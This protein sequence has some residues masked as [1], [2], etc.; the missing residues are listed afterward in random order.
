MHNLCQ[1]RETSLIDFLVQNEN[2]N[3]TIWKLIKNGKII[4]VFLLVL[5]KDPDY[6]LVASSFFFLFFFYLFLPK[7]DNLFLDGKS[8]TFYSLD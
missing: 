4:L 8:D 6:I 2:K 1:H 3:N 7:L 5:I